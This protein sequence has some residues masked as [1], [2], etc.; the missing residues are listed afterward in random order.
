[1]GHGDAFKVEEFRRLI[2]NACYWGLGL[3]EK[4]DAKSNVSILG[5]YDL[6]L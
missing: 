5:A 1:M 6:T 3:E 2:A 4:I